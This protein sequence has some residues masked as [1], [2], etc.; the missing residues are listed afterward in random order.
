M[1]LDTQTYRKL[2]NRV[3]DDLFYTHYHRLEGALVYIDIEQDHVSLNNGTVL[4]PCT[5]LAGGNNFAKR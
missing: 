4:K 5:F 1:T 2:C 3:I